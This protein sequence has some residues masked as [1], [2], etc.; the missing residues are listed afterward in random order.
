MR[1][2]GLLI[3]T[4]VTVMA[5]GAHTEHPIAA[6]RLRQIDLFEPMDCPFGNATSYQIECGY[7]P[8][9]ADHSDPE[10][11]T[12]RLAVAIIH[13][14]NPQPDPILFLAGGPGDSGVVRAPLT[15]VAYARLL[16]TRDLILFD[17]RGAG[18]SQPSLACPQITTSMFADQTAFAEALESM[19]ACSH[20]LQ[21]AYGSLNRFN[22]QQSANDAVVIGTTLGYE[23]INLL[24]VS[25]GTRLGLT[26]IT[27][28]PESIRS[29]VL[30]SVIPLQLNVYEEI[31][32]GFDHA[33][34]QI[35]KLCAADLLCNLAY[36]NIRQR[37]YAIYDQFAANST[38]TERQHQITGELLSQFVMMSLYRRESVSSLLAT[39]TDIEARDFNALD[40]WLEDMPT[41]A[42]GVGVGMTMAVMCADQGTRTSPERVSNSESAFHP[43]LTPD[44]GIF[45]LGGVTLCQAWQQGNAFATPGQ[46]RAATSAIP[47]LLLAGQFDPVTPPYWARLAAETLPNGQVIEAANM[48]HGVTFSHCG[49][50]LTAAYFDDPSQSPEGICSFSPLTF[51]LS[52]RVTRP[53][54]VG[55]A[56]VFGIVAAWGVALAIAAYARQPKYLNPRII[57]QA[58]SPQWIVASIM[59]IGLAIVGGD[60]AQ[61]F[62]GIDRE[63][64]VG[65]IIPLI[66]GAQA[67]LMFS[68]TDEPALEVIA[69]CPRGM[70]W[71]AIERWLG[72]C[73]AQA[74][75]AVGAMVLSAALVPGQS[76]IV[77]LARW[78]PPAILFSGIAFFITIR[79]RVAA[80]GLVMTAVCWFIFAT[81]GKYF[82]PG[83][84]VL[85]VPLNYIQP[86]LWG[87][88]P[89]L[90]PGDLG[91][92][93]YWINRAGVSV[94]GLCLITLAAR[95]LRDAERILLDSAKK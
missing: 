75:V 29:A 16:E 13:S 58:M 24:G 67:A 5:F 62:L 33:L 14:P 95:R 70:M 63:L 11:G 4:L 80:F 68:P 25:Y 64:M 18:M 84:S 27:E 40:D 52:E 50:E 38:T 76:F 90:Q 17:Q 88:H 81:F 35:E 46:D 28:H 78:M 69:A 21:T 43:A 85:F 74:L 41:N 45:G 93:A 15:A 34:T 86:F 12:L 71:I 72:I 47:I 56:I 89:Y 48:G 79:S 22:T 36:P 3:A 82:L 20:E 7:V 49:L 66:V 44:F 23:Q 91:G 39:L 73:A 6:A 10:G 92:T 26:I 83:G 87:I 19:I 94:L 42:G 65:A 77:M 53:V 9:P 59:L 61:T 30:D 54:V 2:I 57:A 55:L 1:K 32:Q 60:R 31:A 8:V 51:E 37:F